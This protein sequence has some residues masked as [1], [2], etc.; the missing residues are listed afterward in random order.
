GRP[1]AR[2]RAI[3]ARAPAARREPFRSPRVRTPSVR[4]RADHASGW[5]RDLVDRAAGVGARPRLNRPLRSTKLNERLGPDEGPATPFAPP[6]ETRAPAVTRPAPSP[7]PTTSPRASKR[8]EERVR[9]RPEGGPITGWLK[10]TTIGAKLTRQMLVV[11]I[12]PLLL[13]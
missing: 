13:L 6:L 2:P 5:S 10:A 1:S 4:G 11:G 8:S 7:A 9:E 3:R 12:V